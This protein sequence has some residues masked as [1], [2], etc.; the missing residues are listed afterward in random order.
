MLTFIWRR[1]SS[2]SGKT[3]VSHRTFLATSGRSLVAPSF[4]LMP[5]H[6]SR[7]GENN[8]PLD[9]L[10][11]STCHILSH[12]VIYTIVA[13]VTYCHILSH[14]V[15]C[16]RH[17]SHHIFSQIMN[18]SIS[19]S[20]LPVTCCHILLLWSSQLKESSDI[21]TKNEPLDLLL[22]PACHIFVQSSPL[23]QLKSQQMYIVLIAPP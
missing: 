23:R 15:T 4:S 5:S 19:S 6:V 8:E 18:C 22:L 2:G 11:S 17:Q 1:T 7:L 12:N 9:L 13:I 21:V 10:L 3:F 16:Y 20:R 14:V